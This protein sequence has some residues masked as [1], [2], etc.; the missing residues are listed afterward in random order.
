MIIAIILFSGNLQF[1]KLFTIAFVILLIGYIFKIQ[2]WKGSAILIE[3]GMLVFAIA[4]FFK[5]IY[6][7]YKLNLILLY[8]SCLIIATAIL[9]KLFHYPYQFEFFITGFS[10][11]VISYLFR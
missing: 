7:T 5:F 4:A 8:I 11:L 10:L 1:G 3:T 9:L 2:H 6:K